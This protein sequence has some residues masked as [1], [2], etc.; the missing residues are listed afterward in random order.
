MNHLGLSK[1]IPDIPVYCFDHFE[2][3]PIGETNPSHFFHTFH[4]GN[5]DWQIEKDG[6]R[7]GKS[8]ELLL[9]ANP[10]IEEESL[11]AFVQRWLFFEV[12]RAV[13]G[14]KPETFWEEKNGR[15]INTE[16]LEDLINKWYE[17]ERAA[18]SVRSYGRILRA[19]RV[20]DEARHYVLNFCTARGPDATNSRWPVDRLVALSIMSIGETLTSAL[21][22]IQEAISFS[23]TGWSNLDRTSLGWGYSGTVLENLVKNGLWCKRTVLMLQGLM[24][25]NTIGLLY[26]V[27][28][29]P[30]HKGRLHLECT[31]DEC[32]I[33]KAEKAK[34]ATPKSGLGGPPP[35]QNGTASK[36][37]ARGSKARQ[38]GER[39]DQAKLAAQTAE[40]AAQ[41]AEK[42]AQ[43]ESSHLFH[44][45]RCPRDGTCKLVGPKTEELN[46]AKK[47]QVPLLY[48]KTGSDEVSLKWFSI[49]E[50]RSQP[51]VVFSH[52]WSDGFGNSSSNRLN[53]CVLNYFMQLFGRLPGEPQPGNV[54]AGRR[55]LPNQSPPFW[56]DTMT[57]PV[58]RDD[59]ADSIKKAIHSMHDV[60][61]FAK[62]TI[63]LDLSLMSK[64]TSK[65]QF[66]DL[67]MSVTVSNW[68]RR[69]WTLQ[70]AYLS[71][72]IWFAL[73]KSRLYS[74][75]DLEELYRGEGGKLHNCLPEACR[76]YFNGILGPERVKI[77]EP[78]MTRKTL[79]VDYQFVAA[80]WKAV[81]WRDTSYSQHETLALA[82]LLDLDTDPYADTSNTTTEAAYDRAKCDELMQMLLGALDAKRAIPPGMIFLPTPQLNITGYGW[83]PRSWLSK[84]QTESPDPLTI[85]YAEAR[86]ERGQGREGL[87]VQ[88]PGFRLYQMDSRKELLKMPEGETISFPA[89]RNL[90]EWYGLREADQGWFFNTAYDTS[91]GGLAIIVPRLPLLNPEEIALLVTIKLEEPNIL[92]VHILHRVWIYRESDATTIK[93]LQDRFNACTDGSMFCGEI[94]PSTQ[95]WCVDREKQPEPPGKPTGEQPGSPTSRRQETAADPVG[96][97]RFLENK[98]KTMTQRL[99]EAAS[100]G[101]SM[102]AREASRTMP[103]KPKDRLKPGEEARWPR[104]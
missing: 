39:K 101:F 12:L 67:A 74:L 59:N 104:I 34:W 55:D 45:P 31:V 20:I 100:S 70:E 75:Q 27:E 60:Y 44:A 29:S 38:K 84:R 79:K 16:K 102:L 15:W 76:A 97:G 56:I 83:A 63:V 19:Q 47:G 26:A 18:A 88:F 1:Q 14:A 11:T 82:T 6:S 9:N 5:L 2:R 25:N 58:K 99:G 42:A 66:L 64:S 90:L 52:V 24:Q 65:E 73:E 89:E 36:S 50:L 8:R 22:L 41:L 4:N 71:K 46:P 85:S 68:M 37:G 53:K 33:E 43:A 103:W 57:I 3:F 23:P 72:Q 28:I 95:Q 92:F 17:E 98:A 86:L 48:Y 51:Y 94:R 96:P 80:V 87:E 78:G 7:T 49:N 62:H 32:A 30:P 77:Q 21:L 93:K 81:Q 35:A 40:E 13:L 54:Y 10:E 61:F 91:S 69:L